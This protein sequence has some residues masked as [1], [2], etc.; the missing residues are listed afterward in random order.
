MNLHARYKKCP[1][2]DACL[3]AMISSTSRILKKE[4]LNTY[5]KGGGT[6]CQKLK[7]KK[8]SNYYF[9]LHGKKNESKLSDSITIKMVFSTIHKWLSYV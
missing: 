7:E 9:I 8:S 3:L 2:F 6:P 1:C 5:Q 4:S